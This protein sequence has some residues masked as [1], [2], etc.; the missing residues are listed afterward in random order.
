MPLLL[1]LKCKSANRLTIVIKNR[2]RVLRF[3]RDE[4]NLNTVCDE[5]NDIAFACRKGRHKYDML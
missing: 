1:M 3:W 2:S 5:E 4:F